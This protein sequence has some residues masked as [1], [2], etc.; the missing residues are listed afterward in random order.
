M[1]PLK[2]SILIVGEGDFSFAAAL[3]KLNSY[4]GSASITATG[5]ERRRVSC[6]QYEQA[7]AH[8]QI[9]QLD[10]NVRVR[11]KVDATQLSQIDFGSSS[12]KYWDSIAR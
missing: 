7:D 5:Y 10:P 12:P 4:Q 6:Q 9:L 8:L 11:H 1:I 2:G 3:S